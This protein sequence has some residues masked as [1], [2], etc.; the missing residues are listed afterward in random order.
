MFDFSQVLELNTQEYGLFCMRSL[1]LG[2]LGEKTNV[3]EN[4]L[5]YLGIKRSLLRSH[6]DLSSLRDV[7]LN[8]QYHPRFFSCPLGSWKS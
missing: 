5:L 1:Y 3:M 8:F 2:R 6:T 4:G 7:I